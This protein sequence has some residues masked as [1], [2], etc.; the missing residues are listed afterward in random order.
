MVRLAEY[1]RDCLRQL[2]AETGIG[3][4]ERTQGTLQLFRTQKQLDGTGADV[5][6]LRRFGVPFE[7]LDRA[8]CLVHEPALARVRGKFVGGLRLPGDETGDCFLFTQRLAA[9]AAGLGAEFRCGTRISR[10]ATAGGVALAVIGQI[11][12]EPGLR[13]RLP[14]GTELPLTRTGYDHF[15]G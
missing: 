10:L 7:L 12:Q 13:C 1:S 11:E 15:A 8:G 5:E 4:D 14:D 6:I 2:R 3:Y 9:M